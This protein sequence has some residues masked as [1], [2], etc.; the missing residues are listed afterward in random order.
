M[1]HANAESARM[2]LGT[3]PVE[4]DGSAYFR[5]PA[6]RPPYFQA[7]DAEGRAV[8]GMRS[9]TYLQPGDAVGASVAMSRW[10]LR[11]AAP[12]FA[13]P[14]AG[15]VGDRT[16]PGR[17][18]PFQLSATG[19]AGA[20]PPLYRLPRWNQGTR[21]KSVGAHRRGGRSLHPL[22]MLP[23]TRMGDRTWNDSWA[24]RL[25]RC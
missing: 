17:D 21:E 19:A 9:V 15:A 4:V 2:L 14:G 23:D 25:R 10:A 3:V 7:V 16:R 20:R 8:Q 11:L 18:A 12:G 22:G 1:G 5:V 13:G 6:R 24:A